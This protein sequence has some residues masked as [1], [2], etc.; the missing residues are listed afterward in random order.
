MIPVYY[1]YMKVPYDGRQI[2]LAW[3]HHPTCLINYGLLQYPEIPIY[4]DK[5][6]FDTE[7]FEEAESFFDSFFGNVPKIHYDPATA[8]L[9]I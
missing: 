8:K 2:M 4:M 7:F 5:V 9:I 6:L 1:L 3:S